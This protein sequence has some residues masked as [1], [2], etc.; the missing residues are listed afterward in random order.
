MMREGGI[1]WDANLYYTE[2][3]IGSLNHLLLLRIELK[4][5]GLMRLKY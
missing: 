5:Q 2:T 4:K 1:K 3:G